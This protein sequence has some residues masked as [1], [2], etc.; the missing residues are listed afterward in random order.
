MPQLEAARRDQGDVVRLPHTPVCFADP[1]AAKAVLGN[2]D[3][4][5]REH[6]DF[7]HIRH[8]IF[9][10]RQAQ[11]DIARAGRV[12]LRER[13]AEVFAAV[14]EAVAR[15]LVGVGSSVGAG[16][17]VAETEWPDAGNRLVYDL[18]ADLLVGR[19]RDPAQRALLNEIFERGVLA[20][21]R[22]RYSRRERARFRK[23]A[24]DGLAEAV[25]QSRRAGSGH[26]PGD[27]LDVVALSAGDQPDRDVAE[28][29]ISHV[30]ALTGSV[31]FALG[32]SVLL[33]GGVAPE[34]ARH[35]WVVR[36]ALRMW[37]VAWLFGRTVAQDHELAGTRLRRDDDVIVCSYLV[38]RHPEHWPEPD[39]FRPERWADLTG[40]PAYLP[41]GWGPHSCTG[42]AIALELVERL[43]EEIFRYEVRV[44]ARADR[45]DMG[46]ALA[47]PL[48][49][50]RATARTS[51]C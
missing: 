34:S 11:V 38:H 16:I 5:F 21:A 46:P 35:G 8:G 15:S 33:T 13:M 37:P 25:R 49:R 18:T 47:P 27:L 31:G 50:V 42:A 12:F 44:S 41:F 51:T 3:G 30:F 6:S 14:P 1:E 17:G 7:F 40:P 43:L 45:P 4:L 10:P 23:R 28:V 32:W 22:G 19:H 9:G 2:P 20:G 39:A 24:F 29:F 48:F 36:E 26:P